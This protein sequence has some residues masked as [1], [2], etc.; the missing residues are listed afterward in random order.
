MVMH[1]KLGC[2]L[3]CPG[4]PHCYAPLSALRVASSPEALG[5]VVGDGQPVQHGDGKSTLADRCVC[6]GQRGTLHNVVGVRPLPPSTTLYHPLP[7]HSM[8]KV[9]PPSPSPV[10]SARL[11]SAFD[12]WGHHIDGAEHISGLGHHGVLQWRRS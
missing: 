11:A 12:A 2:A 1:S 4:L 9:H 8:P 7:P 10:R 3:L 6:Q 5:D